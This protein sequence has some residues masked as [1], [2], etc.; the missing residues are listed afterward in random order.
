LP[1]GRRNGTDARTEGRE[2]AQTARRRE[3]SRNHPETPRGWP[4]GRCNAQGERGEIGGDGDSMSDYKTDQDW[5][6]GELELKQQDLERKEIDETIA[7]IDSG[8]RRAIVGFMRMARKE[9]AEVHASECFARWEIGYRAQRP[10]AIQILDW[11]RQAK[12]PQERVDL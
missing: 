2:N 12:D 3:E 7:G 4:E 8:L 5:L 6:M 11:A 9:L 1:N 10:R